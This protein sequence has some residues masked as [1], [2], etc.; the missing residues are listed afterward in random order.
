VVTCMTVESGR[1][2]AD[3]GLHH[4]TFSTSGARRR[5]P[6]S[7]VLGIARAEGTRSDHEGH[8]QAVAKAGDGFVTKLGPGLGGYVSPVDVV[9]FSGRYGGVHGAGP[10]GLCPIAAPDR[11]W[12]NDPT[13]AAPTRGVG[14][15][16]GGASSVAWDLP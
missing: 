8:P 14:S 3:P 1:A 12:P 4:A 6:E 15:G 16:N 13:G 2:I 9:E 5:L 7:E 10:F 11:D